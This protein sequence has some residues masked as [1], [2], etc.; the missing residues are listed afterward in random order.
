MTTIGTLRHRLAVEAPIRTAEDG[1]AA[2]YTWTG[3]GSVYAQVKPAGGREIVA[4]DGQAS[5]VTHEVMI[6]Y[7]A[8]IDAT[9]RFVEGTRIL[10]I[11]AALDVDGRRRWLR[12]LCEERLP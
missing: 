6:R 12:C 7:N 2:S 8:G 5:R 1:G 4:A 9:M 10:D 3:T 11:R